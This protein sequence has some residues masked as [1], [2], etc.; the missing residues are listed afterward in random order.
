MF[1]GSILAMTNEE[2]L[3]ISSVNWFVRASHACL[4]SK[5]QEYSSQKYKKEKT[6]DKRTYYLLSDK[7]DFVDVERVRNSIALHALDTDLSK[8]LETINLKGNEPFTEELKY[9][10]SFISGFLEGA[11]LEKGNISDISLKIAMIMSVN[12]SWEDSI[13][14]FK[15]LFTDSGKELDETL[16]TFEKSVFVIFLRI[17][18]P[19]IFRYLYDR[20]KI[21]CE[22]KFYVECM[23]KAIKCYI[24]TRK[25]ITDDSS[26][27]LE[28]CDL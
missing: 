27:V 10:A 8:L 11:S 15:T 9:T 4:P 21:E 16:F 13:A 12:L 7:I 23:L 17:D 6:V 28:E 25:T 3:K 2:V 18:S 14:L 22:R 20:K 26:A 19:F 24:E 1:F 5:V